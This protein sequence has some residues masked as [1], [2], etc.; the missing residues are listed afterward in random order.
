MENMQF[1][2]FFTKRLTLKPPKDW[3]FIKEMLLLV[4]LC[5]QFNQKK[6]FFIENLQRGGGG[7]KS[8]F[9]ALRNK[10]MAPKKKGFLKPIT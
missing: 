5:S 3:H 4:H 7:L 2:K 1:F 9:F 8:W 10:W 6:F